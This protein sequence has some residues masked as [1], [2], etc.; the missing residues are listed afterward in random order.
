[1]DVG[2]FRGNAPSFIVHRSSSSSDAR[3]FRTLRRST[4]SFNVSKITKRWTI[5]WN[6]RPSHSHTVKGLY[7]NCVT[8]K[9]GKN[10]P[11]PCH[12]TVT[13]YEHMYPP[14]VTSRFWAII[15]I[16]S[17]TLFNIFNYQSIH[18]THTNIHTQ[19]NIEPV[20]PWSALY[21]LSGQKQIFK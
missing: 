2:A 11:S 14:H 3:A 10:P 5:E 12:A 18:A 16:T 6:A 9:I 15:L 1:M 7:F 13:L 21:V 17:P 19:N 8:Q 4:L 20:S